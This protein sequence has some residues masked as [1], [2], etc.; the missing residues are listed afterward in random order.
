MLDVTPLSLDIETLGEVF[1]K[2][3][4]RNT[5]IPTSKS[6][7]FSTATDGQTSVEIHVL[8]G[9]RAMAQDNRSL[10]KCLLAG[11]PPAPRGVPQIEVSFQS[12]LNAILKV[13][14]KAA[15][16]RAKA[17]PQRTLELKSHTTRTMISKALQI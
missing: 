7:V 12:D 16:A 15:R 13:A 6:Q 17:S 9:E 4:E 14:A 11:I 2:I 8:Q 1:T 5:T 10:G 3:I